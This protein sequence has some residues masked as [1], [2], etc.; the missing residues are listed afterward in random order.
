MSG[1]ITKKSG[2]LETEEKHRYGKVENSN[3][4][5][6]FEVIP[7]RNRRSIA[8][9]GII[10][11]MSP[12]VESV[13]RHR[14]QKGIPIYQTQV[15]LGSEFGICPSLSPY[16]R[17]YVGFVDTDNPVVYLMAS[18][19]KHSK[20]LFVKRLDDPVL[21]L[22]FMIKRYNPQRRLAVFQSS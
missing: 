22:K 11:K 1:V 19:F 6:D 4:V 20:L 15:D 7:S 14:V 5:T 9:F 8:Y 13:P 12:F 16:D 3:E 10:L 21:P 17:T 2:Y 18:A